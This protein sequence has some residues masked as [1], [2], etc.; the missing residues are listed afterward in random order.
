[1]VSFSGTGLIA[2]VAVQIRVQH[3]KQSFFSSMASCACSADA[4]PHPQIKR[5]LERCRITAARLH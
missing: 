2:L 5:V 1:M 3:V 4:D